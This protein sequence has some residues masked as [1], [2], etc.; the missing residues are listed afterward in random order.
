MGTRGMWESELIES[1]DITKQLS[2][3]GHLLD[4][5]GANPINLALQQEDVE[6]SEQ[7]ADGI[8]CGRGGCHEGPKASESQ[9]RQKRVIR[10]Q[11]DLLPRVN[12]R[13][14]YVRTRQ[15][16]G[17]DGAARTATRFAPTKSGRT[18]AEMARFSSISRCSTE[19][20]QASSAT[21][22]YRLAPYLASASP[23]AT[24][25]SSLPPLKGLRAM[26]IVGTRDTCEPARSH[27]ARALG[28]TPLHA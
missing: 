6:A 2:T 4:R 19:S 20:F 7:G 3:L 23:A 9:E 12:L 13:T 14:K 17:K 26:L 24:K 10:K 18:S 16:R 11:L 22:A 1:Q 25:S 21:A 27:A 8:A 5:R 28:C 15:Q